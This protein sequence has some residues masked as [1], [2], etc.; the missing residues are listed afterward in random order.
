VVVI[1]RSDVLAADQAGESEDHALK[2]WQRSLE[3]AAG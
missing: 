1:G 3:P 2:A